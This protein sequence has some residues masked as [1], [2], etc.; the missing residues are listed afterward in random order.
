MTAVLEVETRVEDIHAHQGA[1]G[2]QHDDRARRGSRPPGAER[3]GEVDPDQDP[4]RIPRAR[5]GRWYP[6]PGSTSCRSSHR[7]SPTGS[8]AGSCSRI[9]GSSRR[10][11]SWTTWRSG[12]AFP[13]RSGR[14]GEGHLRAGQGGSGEARPRHRSARRWWPRSAPRSAP[15]WPSPAH[16]ARIRNT[17]PACSCSTSRRR[18]LPVDEVDHLLD[19]VSAMAA[20]GVGV[21]Y[22]THH[23][24]EVFRVAHK[25]SVFRDG[26]VVGA[27]PVKRLRPRRDRRAARRRGAA[28]RGDRVPT[29]E[30]RAGR[31]PAGPRDRIRGQ[32]PARRSAGGSV[33]Q[34]RTRRDRR[35]RRSR[36]LRSRQRARR[37]LRRAAA[38][39]RRGDGSP[40]QPL[41][42]GPA[43]RRHRPRR[44]L[45]GARPE[46][47]RRR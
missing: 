25:V 46:D 20:T 3:I 29:A 16:C 5:S 34:R 37:Q 26:V 23:L 11:R 27:G 4:L 44:R 31:R 41:P 47:R 14:S 13:P 7:C 1:G 28:R 32:G 43:R 15:A 24:G 21:L 33:L 12:R 8:D 6:D 42:A 39:R 40:A 35:D 45:P 22:V 36:R 38:H 9:S 2:R 19:R 10:C 17:R 18:R 30:G